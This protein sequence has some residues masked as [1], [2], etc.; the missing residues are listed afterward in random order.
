M[1]KIVFVHP[2]NMMH[3]IAAWLCFHLVDYEGAN[4]VTPYPT[5]SAWT[6]QE[7]CQN[8]A[9][10]DAFTYQEDK[11]HLK[12]LAVQTRKFGYQLSGQNTCK[13]PLN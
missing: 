3:L 10:C 2:E 6:C 12:E 8:H 13:Y 7:E 1:F 5:Q 9:T 4:L 11:C